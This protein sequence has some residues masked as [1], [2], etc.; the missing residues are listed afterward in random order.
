VFTR[1]KRQAAHTIYE[2]SIRETYG[3]LALT[4]KLPEAPAF[5]EA[6]ALHATVATSKPRSAAAKAV[7]AIAGEIRARIAARSA[8]EQTEAA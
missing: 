8:A 5:V 3:E 6:A 1:A 2:E 4:A 7:A